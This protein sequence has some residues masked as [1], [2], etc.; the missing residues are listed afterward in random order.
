MESEG[1]LIAI[2]GVHSWDVL[3]CV[4]QVVKLYVILILNHWINVWIAY[5]VLH[6]LRGGSILTKLNMKKGTKPAE[7][8]ASS[9]TITPSSLH[10]CMHPNFTFHINL[11]GFILILLK[12]AQLVACKSSH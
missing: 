8:S 3:I 9:S 5:S 2:K 1:K 10:S 12:C 7:A 6:R 11:M 4:S